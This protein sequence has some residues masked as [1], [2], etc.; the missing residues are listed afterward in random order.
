MKINFRIPVLPKR[1]PCQVARTFVRGQRR[2]RGRAPRHWGEP[3]RPKT[4][5]SSAS[6]CTIQRFFLTRWIEASLLCSEVAP[7]DLVEDALKAA[8]PCSKVA[9]ADSVEDPLDLVVTCAFFVKRK[10]GKGL[11]TRA[12]TYTSVV[13]SWV[14]CST[15]RFLDVLRDPTR[16]VKNISGS[17]PTQGV[18]GILVANTFTRAFSRRWAPAAEP[19]WTSD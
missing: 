19:I 10:N 18:R 2:K 17:K 11:N 7:A 3:L 5:D 6:S 9:L 12:P 15:L 4:D 16:A 8:P 1:P 14:E 13:L